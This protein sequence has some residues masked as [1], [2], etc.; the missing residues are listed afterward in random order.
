MSGAIPHSPNR[1]S[2]RGAQLKKS[3]GTTLPLHL[4]VVVVTTSR[5]TAMRN[6]KFS[7]QS[8]CLAEYTYFDNVAWCLKHY[9]SQARQLISSENWTV[10][11]FKSKV[12]AE[13][14]HLH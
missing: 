1:P 2:W 8:R 6:L 7:Q 4:V 3:T 14:K 13:Q 5:D 10:T 9:V 12:P 11:G